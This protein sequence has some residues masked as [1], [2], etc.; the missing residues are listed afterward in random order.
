MGESWLAEIAY[1]F[2]ES[3]INFFVSLAVILLVMYFIAYNINKGDQFLEVMQ[4]LVYGPL[5][6]ALDMVSDR[7]RYKQNYTNML[8]LK[9]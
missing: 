3:I 6:I 1:S 8:K 7:V 9:N 5:E 2:L 4:L